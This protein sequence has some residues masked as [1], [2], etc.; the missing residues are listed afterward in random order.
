MT[1]YRL[2]NI[3]FHGTVLNVVCIGFIWFQLN[4]GFI[5]ASLTIEMPSGSFCE[6]DAI[7]ECKES[8]C[9]RYDPYVQKNSPSIFTLYAQGMVNDLETRIFR[10]H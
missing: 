2:R 8:D 9:I 4:F 7:D 5:R 6:L 1:M 10:F 3:W